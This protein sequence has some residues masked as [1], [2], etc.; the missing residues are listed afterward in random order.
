MEHHLLWSCES[1]GLRGRPRPELRRRYPLW[2]NGLRVILPKIR[3]NV[4]PAVE[5]VSP[6]NC[7]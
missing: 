5:K 4:S 2:I 7:P 3:R 6:A 1:E